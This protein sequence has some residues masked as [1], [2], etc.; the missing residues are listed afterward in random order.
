MNLEYYVPRFDHNQDRIV[1][2]NI[3]NSFR[4]RDAVE[5]E[6]KKYIRSP[7]KYAKTSLRDGSTIYGFDAFVEEVRSCIMWVMCS[8]F[9][10][11]IGVGNYFSP[12]KGME[13]VDVYWLCKPNVAV[14]AREIIY[15]AKE[16]RKKSAG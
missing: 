14:I 7:K 3:F 2:I 11:E 15:Q 10:Y 12:D 8:R 13:K 5:K 16:E 4:L 1:M 6:A 9:E